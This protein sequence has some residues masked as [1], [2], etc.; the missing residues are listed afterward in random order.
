MAWP[1]ENHDGLFSATQWSLL[2]P[3]ALQFFSLATS[4]SFFALTF[5]KQVGARCNF[6]ECN[7]FHT[8]KA[9]I[10]AQ[11]PRTG[12]RFRRICSWMLRAYSPGAL[13]IKHS[14]GKF[15]GGCNYYAHSIENLMEWTVLCVFT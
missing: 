14:F 15:L 11:R 6:Y 10:S 9:I 5:Q 1:S 8:Q 12:L 4:G 7:T 3:L 2:T 13:S